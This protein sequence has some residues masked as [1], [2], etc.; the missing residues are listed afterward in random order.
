MSEPVTPSTPDPVTPSGTA[1]HQPTPPRE[2][3]SRSKKKWILG[4]VI[5]VIVLAGIGSNGGSGKPAATP[6]PTPATVVT[7]APTDSATLV[8]TVAPTPEPTVAPTPEPTVAPTPEPTPALTAAQRNA[9]AEAQSYL[10]YQSFSLQGLIDQL[11]FVG[12]TKAQATYGATKA[13]R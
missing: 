13:Y 1:W 8:P 7:Q 11:V 4:G 5:G 2:P 6:A 3:K 9:I 12:F 10:T